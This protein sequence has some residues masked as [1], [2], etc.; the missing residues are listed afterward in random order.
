MQLRP[1]DWPRANTRHTQGTRSQAP[2]C[3]LGATLRGTDREENPESEVE[4]DLELVLQ[5]IPGLV[6]HERVLAGGFR[7]GQLGPGLQGSRV[8]RVLIASP[9]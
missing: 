4:P 8:Q 2:G 1:A 7:R 5:L 9:A 3:L 6:G